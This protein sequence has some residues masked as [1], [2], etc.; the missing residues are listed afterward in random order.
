MNCYDY[1]FEGFK[2]QTYIVL[3]NETHG[4]PFSSPTLYDVLK[5]LNI[6]TSY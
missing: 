1:S 5:Y 2:I 3:M 6:L 4:K